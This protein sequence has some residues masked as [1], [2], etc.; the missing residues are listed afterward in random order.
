MSF[1]LNYIF[2]SPQCYVNSLID[3]NNKKKNS[4]NYFIFFTAGGGTGFI[5]TNLVKLLSS[6]GYDVTIVSRMPGTRR[7]TWHELENK[8]LPQ[9]TVAVVNVCGQNVLDPTRRWSPGLKQNVWTS[10]VNSAASLVK[11]IENA[12][13]KPDVFINLSGIALYKPDKDKVYT[14][15]DAGEEYDFMSKLCVHWEKAATLADGTIPRQVILHFCWI[16]DLLS[17]SLPNSVDSY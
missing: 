9:N 16:M 11:A 15:D 5:G 8:G 14:E 2:F 1:N 6:S 17:V 7:I 10:R 13:V 3:K 4:L 12:Q